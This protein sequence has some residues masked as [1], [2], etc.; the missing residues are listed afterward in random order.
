M[1]VLLV[2][3]DAMLADAMARR[4]HQQLTPS[5]WSATRGRRWR[6]LTT[7]CDIV[8]RHR[9]AG[10]RQ[11]P[12][13]EARAHAPLDGSGARDD[14]ADTIEDRVGGL[15]LGA[16]DY[17]PSRFT[18]P[19]WRRACGRS[20]GARISREARISSRPREARYIGRRLFCD[21]DPLDVS[22]REFAVLDSF[23]CAQAKW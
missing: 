6:L 20:S 10:N 14:R 8:S 22:A 18:S 16:N 23:C 19:S 5:I 9:A 21:N 7:G 4:S 15:D 3:D 13:A 11:A 2:E 17:I 1:R 12:G